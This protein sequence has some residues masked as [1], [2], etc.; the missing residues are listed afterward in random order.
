MAMNGLKRKAVICCFHQK[1][2]ILQT[3]IKANPFQKNQ[4]VGAFAA[5]IWKAVHGREM[6]LFFREAAKPIDRVASRRHPK[7][8][9]APSTN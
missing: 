2:F 3:S 6:Q 8:E 1:I 4:G 5:Y 9:E 7:T